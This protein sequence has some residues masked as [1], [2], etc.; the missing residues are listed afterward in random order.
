MIVRK[1]I[2]ALG[3]TTATAKAIGV[4]RQTVCAWA[5]KNVI[6]KKWAGKIMDLTG[7]DCLPPCA[8]RET[9][10]EAQ[11]TV[12]RWLKKSRLG[13][14]FVQR[15]MAG[16]DSK[17]RPDLFL[18][19]AGEKMFLFVK[20]ESGRMS[21]AAR[22]AQEDLKKKGFRVEVARGSRHAIE[23]IKNAFGASDNV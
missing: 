21:R 4:S 20:T 18:P 23:I 15:N 5:R 3:G 11:R 12:E 7:I 2:D 19:L 22:A 16:G 1:I 13:V 14:F 10:R 8:H 17:H 6:H 9:K